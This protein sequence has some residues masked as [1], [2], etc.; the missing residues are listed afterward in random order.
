MYHVRDIK[1]Y[2]QCPKM[3][4]LSYHHHDERENYNCRLDVDL[5]LLA[6]QFLQLNEYY[7]GTSSDKNEQ[8]FEKMKQYTA[9]VDARFE[10]Q[11]LRVKIPI[12][13]KG[14][15]GWKVYFTS[16]SLFPKENEVNSLSHYVWVLLQLSIDIE[17]IDIIHVN[18]NYIR[19]DTLNPTQCLLMSSSFYTDS[20]KKGRRIKKVLLEKAHR[21]NPV[22]K[23]M[24]EVVALSRSEIDHSVLCTKHK[25]CS[26]SQLC[27]PMI[28]EDKD[29]SIL[30]L[31][32]SH[33]KVKMKDEG[34]ELL[35]NV[36][37]QLVEGTRQQYAQIRA[38]QTES[39][40]FYDRLALKFWLQDI[41]YPISFLDF[42]WDSFVIPPYKGMKANEALTFQYSLHILNE[43]NELIHKEYLGTGDCR[44]ELIQQLIRDLPKKGTIFSYNAFGAEMLR[45]NE[46]MK[47]NKQYTRPLKNAIKRLK[48][49]SDPFIMGVVYAIKMK[50]QY[51][52][53]SVMG[54]L[55]SEGYYNDLQIAKG[56]DAVIQWRQLDRNQ[57]FD[58]KETREMLLQYCSM[59]T[60][61]LVKLYEWLNELIQ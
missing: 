54:A 42:E 40:I 55:S 20:E 10:A 19:Q 8:T 11:S 39:G 33:N 27:Q 12:M 44:D 29:D 5:T 51:S 49:M 25:Q 31:I 3:F 4:W 45:L 14:E 34:I 18:S 13:V 35:K 24:D 58:T 9:L 60:L 56:V 7:L 50:G 30:T 47:R 28:H 43:H 36:N 59:D 21:I 16:S 6:V 61:A 1:K 32:N 22:V 57:Q 46:M 2:A 53:K 52:L 37:L 41:S 38:S 15:S 26:Y 48:D 17:S 23:K